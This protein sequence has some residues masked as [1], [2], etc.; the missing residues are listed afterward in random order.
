MELLN[1][2]VER[3]NDDYIYVVRQRLVASRKSRGWRLNS[4]I[5]TF[6]SWRKTRLETARLLRS[7]QSH[8]LITRKVK[9]QIVL[10]EECLGGKKSRIHDSHS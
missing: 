9:N 7:D 10:R 1:G 2:Q 8:S 3:T 5:G 6:S 4:L